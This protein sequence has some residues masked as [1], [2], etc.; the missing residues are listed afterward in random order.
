MELE[1]E[2]ELFRRHLEDIANGM[3]VVQGEEEEKDEVEQEQEQ[4]QE[5]GATPSSPE[6]RERA[7]RR[8]LEIATRTARMINT[9]EDPVF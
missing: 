2:K 1:L 7:W 9:T 5:E 8:E 6:L 3:V 4:E